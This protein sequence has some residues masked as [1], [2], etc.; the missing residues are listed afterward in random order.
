MNKATKKTMQAVLDAPLVGNIAN[1]V[2]T[3]NIGK[4][5]GK[6]TTV[7]K[8]IQI[9]TDEKSLLN[10]KIMLSKLTEVKEKLP[11]EKLKSISNTQRIIKAINNDYVVLDDFL[12]SV[13]SYIVKN[14][15][16]VDDK[17]AIKVLD[18]LTQAKEILSFI[19]DYLKFS[20]EIAQAK[21]ELKGKKAITFDQLEKLIC[22]S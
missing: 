14:N 22:V 19:S 11:T 2:K 9:A 13:N 12:C 15:V 18:N 8:V 1:H 4:A 10:S 16:E 3:F 5:W 21:E 20:L 17:N 7:Q 6:L